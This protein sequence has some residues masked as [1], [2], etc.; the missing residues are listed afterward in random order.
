MPAGLNPI[1]C[2]EIERSGVIPP[3]CKFLNPTLHFCASWEGLLIDANDPEFSRCRCQGVSRGAN[4][5]E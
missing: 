3:E 2:N 1:Q 4:Q 5:S